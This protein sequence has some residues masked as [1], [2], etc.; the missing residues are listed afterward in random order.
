MAITSSQ[1]PLIGRFYEAVFGLKAA[2]KSRPLNGFTV[3]DGYVG[4]NINPRRDRMTGCLD[5]F[6]VVVDDLDATIARMRTK[7]G[8]D[9]IKRPSTRPFAA[10]TA[11]D[12]DGNF[13]D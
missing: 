2:G 4:L 3:G 1:W 6:G 11:H 13:F 10:Y 7:W 5:H 12:P 8:V 9:L